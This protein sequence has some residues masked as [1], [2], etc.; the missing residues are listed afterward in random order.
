MDT[1]KQNT[2]YGKWLEPGY[3]FP[4]T[5]IEETKSEMNNAKRQ[6][7]GELSE[8]VEEFRDMYRK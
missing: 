5:V 1:Y 6:V 4:D 2:G 8:K 7:E 3:L